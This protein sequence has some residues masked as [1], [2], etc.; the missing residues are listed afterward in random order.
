MPARLLVCWRSMHANLRA[1]DLSGV[2]SMFVPKE[3]RPVS[4]EVRTR[5]R[6]YLNAKRR[7]SNPVS[8]L[9]VTSVKQSRFVG[10]PDTVRLTAPQQAKSHG[11]A[12]RSRHGFPLTR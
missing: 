9:V 6:D 5:A 4:S 11:T 8:C 10:L 2:P 7:A 12:L 3:A 1:R